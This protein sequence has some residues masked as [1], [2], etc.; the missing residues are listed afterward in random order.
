MKTRL[1]VAALSV[2][3]LY[4]PTFADEMHKLTKTDTTYTKGVLRD[5]GRAIGREVRDMVE[6]EVRGRVED[7]IGIS[8]PEQANGNTENN[9]NHY[10]WDYQSQYQIVGDNPAS[11]ITEAPLNTPH[12]ALSIDWQAVIRGEQT[13]IVEGDGKTHVNTERDYLNRSDR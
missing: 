5:M 13:V 11:T 7:A 3:L 10:G 1:I 9:G 8:L 2:F 4:T 12:Q 6:Q